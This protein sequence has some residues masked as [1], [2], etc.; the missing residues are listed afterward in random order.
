V[1]R[2]GSR[3]GLGAAVALVA[4]LTAS[5]ALAKPVVKTVT[6]GPSPA[7]NKV[8]AKLVPKSF[9]KT[10][11]P[12]INAF[13]NKKVTINVGDTVAFQIRGFHTIDIPAKGGTPLPLLVPGKIATGSDFAG[14][15]FWWSGHVPTIGFNPA[16]LAPGKS[17]VYNGKKRLDTGLPLGKPK[18]FNITFSKPGTYKYFCDVHPG[19]VGTVV[20]KP[21]GAAI[22]SA[23]QDAKATVAQATAAVKAAK[24]AAVA[25]V[26]ADTV[27]LG[28]TG[29][30]GVELFGMFPS[31]LTVS[32]GTTV[33]FQMSTR[34]FEVH[35][36]TFGDKKTLTALA[37]GFQGIPFPSQGVYPSDPPGTITESL[38]S[39]GN[40]F[41]NTGVLDHN[42]ATA[43]ILPSSQIKFT[44]AGT[45]HFIC[46]IHP[47]MHGTIIVK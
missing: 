44:Q 21:D 45:Y 11:S 46:L 41:A 28:K 31:S 19:M 15:P 30:G 16:L 1:R 3:A 12:D 40:G 23:K 8:A 2:I 35:T 20:V 42:S 22:P 34:S 36:A 17:A 27:S 47:F 5:A 6:A 29:P 38:T 33:T 7:V 25:K 9:V 26:P 14:S 43:Q 13:F 39:H 18:P 32:A 10:Y 24:K 37:K 4:L